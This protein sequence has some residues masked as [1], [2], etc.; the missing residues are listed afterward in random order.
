M[1]RPKLVRR[2]GFET[3]LQIGNAK[4]VEAC[5]R[6]IEKDLNRRFS[7]RDL[8]NPACDSY[9]D[10]L[11]KE[12][13]ET[14]GPKG[15]GETVA[16]FI[17]DLHTT[18][19]N[20]GTSVILDSED[21]LAWQAA[22]ALQAGDAELTIFT[23]KGDTGESAFVHTIAPSGFALELG[24]IPQGV[25]RADIFLRTAAT[26]H[27]LLDFFERF[28]RGEAEVVDTAEIYEGVGLLD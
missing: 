22:A 21:P 12:I 26:V 5:V 2:E 4:A 11:A 9:E 25:L 3:L 16:D 17:V 18:T 20:M 6:Y 15:S 10:L 24:P 27:Q 13:N 14:L 1:R 23:W 7:L 19:S 8:S 28:H